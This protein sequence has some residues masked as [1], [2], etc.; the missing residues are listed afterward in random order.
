MGLILLLGLI[1]GVLRYPTR[2]GGSVA[3][4]IAVTTF[5]AAVLGTFLGP[6]V[7]RPQRM[8]FAVGCGLYLLLVLAEP[9][10]LSTTLSAGG[11]GPASSHSN[12]RLISYS[13]PIFTTFLLDAAF[14]H[15]SVQPNPSPFLL[16]FFRVDNRAGVEE[17]WSDWTKLDVSSG[18]SAGASES[19][20]LVG[21]S[22]FA[23]LAGW[24]GAAFSC[25]LARRASLD[26][27]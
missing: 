9:A 26:T 8:G 16:G 13:R 2:L 22:A 25:R 4:T 14:P 15:V 7:E 20:H 3:F 21:H 6:R 18:A 27:P 5:G 19:F 12:A 10:E 23:L 1:L 24:L 11:P 17:I